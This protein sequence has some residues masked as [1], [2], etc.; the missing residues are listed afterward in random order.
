[1]QRLPALIGLDASSAS[2]FTPFTFAALKTSTQPTV[3]EAPAESNSPCHASPA[4]DAFR[5]RH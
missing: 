5:Y 3:P 2:L 4:Q 1:V